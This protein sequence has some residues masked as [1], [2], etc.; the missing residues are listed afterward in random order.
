MSVQGKKRQRSYDLL[1]VKTKL[2]KKILKWLEFFY[3]LHQAQ[4]LAPLITLYKAF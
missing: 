2:K 4:T 1:N 3:G